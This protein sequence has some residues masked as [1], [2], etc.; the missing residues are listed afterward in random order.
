[1]K[2]ERTN[3][4]FLQLPFSCLKRRRGK[5]NLFSLN[6]PTGKKPSLQRI[7]KWF[8]FT[9]PL[10]WVFPASIL[11]QLRIRQ[12][13]DQYFYITASAT[14]LKSLHFNL[15]SLPSLL[16][17]DSPCWIPAT[18]GRSNHSPLMMACPSARLIASTHLGKSCTCLLALWRIA[19]L[20]LLRMSTSFTIPGI[21]CTTN[22]HL[23]H[24]QPEEIPYAFN[25]M[26]FY[27]M[28]NSMTSERCV[29][30][31]ISRTT[32]IWFKMLQKTLWSDESDTEYQ[33][34]SKKTD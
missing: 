29:L 3:L 1:M 34:W 15:W 18:P 25:N 13:T 12:V 27:K 10:E 14:D 30:Y 24:R 17:P 23:H 20:C 16:P 28:F 33:I 4:C 32:Q 5:K 2:N 11:E 9:T 19:S 31:I 22:T 8:S 26:I 21:N 6:K 7:L